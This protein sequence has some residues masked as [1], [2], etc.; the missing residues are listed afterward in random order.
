MVIIISVSHAIE[1][2]WGVST[3]SDSAMRHGRNGKS[4]TTRGNFLQM[5]NDRI[6]SRPV[7]TFHLKY[8]QEEPRGGG[9][10]LMIIRRR[11]YK[12]VLSVQI[13]L[14][15]QMTV[16]SIVIHAMKATGDFAILV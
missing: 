14:H 13:V 7:D 10:S 5:Q 4:E 2:G 8:N 12:V 16:T 6:C 15:G 1:K 9:R 3:G 11:D